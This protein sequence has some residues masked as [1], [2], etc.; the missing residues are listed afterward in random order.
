MDLGEL[1]RISLHAD[2]DI[3]PFY[4]NNGYEGSSNGGGWPFFKTGPVVM[5]KLVPRCQ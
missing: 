2:T 4:G 5:S 3:A 1:N